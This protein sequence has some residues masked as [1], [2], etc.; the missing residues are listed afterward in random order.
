MVREIFM[1]ERDKDTINNCLRGVESVKS[2]QEDLELL[3]ENVKSKKRKLNEI[4]FR[5]RQLRGRPQY[6]RDQWRNSLRA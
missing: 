4:I 3:R 1:E 6:P 2:V 5:A